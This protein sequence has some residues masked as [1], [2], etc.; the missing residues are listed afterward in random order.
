[1]AICA[2]MVDWEVGWCQHLPCFPRCRHIIV[3]AIE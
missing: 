2:H 3:W 1:M